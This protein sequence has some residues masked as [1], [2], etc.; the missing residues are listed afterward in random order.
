MAVQRIFFSKHGGVL[1]HG[2]PHGLLLKMS[3]KTKSL[4]KKVPNL[5]FLYEDEELL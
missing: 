5:P 2:D 3:N 4:V 1:F